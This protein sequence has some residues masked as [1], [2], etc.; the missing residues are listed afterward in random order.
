MIPTSRL[1]LLEL[2]LH[3]LTQLQV[4]RAERLVEQQHRRAVDDRAGQGDALALPARELARLA[5]AVA[6]QPHHL[7]RLVGAL[8]RVP[9]CGTFFTRRPYSTF[10]RTR[11][12]REERVVLE[13][14]VDVARVGRHVADV[15]ALR[16]RSG[17]ASGRSNPA[18]RRRRGGLS[19][20]GWAKHREEL[21]RG[22]LEIDVAHGVD[23]SV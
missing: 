5:V 10:S 18:I 12:V 19:R 22:D 9:A 21:A 13:D 7:E 16:A 1:D 15:A 23:R 17:P 2:D 14:R 4:E 11:H 6:G 3:L 8:R 20:P